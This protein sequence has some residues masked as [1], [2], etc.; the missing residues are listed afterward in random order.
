MP[1]LIASSR[2]NSPQRL[3]QWLVPGL[4][5]F[6]AAGILFLIAGNWTTWA[7]ERPSQETDD[8]YLRADLT[9]LSTKVAGLVAT[10]N[11]SDYQPVKSRDPLVELRDDDF[12]AQVQQ[13]EAAVAAGEDSLINNQRQK[14]LQDAHII[15]ADDG[16]RAAEADIAAGEAAL[17]RQNP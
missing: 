11:V 9:P 13:A 2:P 10:V 5:L 8:A 15:Q 16:I 14:E 3:K 1:D 12:R 17:K 7:S 4:I 6:M